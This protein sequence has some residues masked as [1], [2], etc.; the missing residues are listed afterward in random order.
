[1][2]QLSKPKPII[3]AASACVW[4]ERE[5][6]LIKRGND[7]GKGFWS[8][9]GGK[10][11]AGETLQACAHRELYEET[12]VT[13]ELALFVGEFPLETPQ[14]HFEIH[15]FTGHY[16]AGTACANTDALDVAWVNLE[17]LTH[18]TLTPHV[19]AAMALAFKLISV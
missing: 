2:H 4:R 10:L 17:D 16:V 18:F 1:M 11:E 6:L 13:A 8:L 14:A 5:V 19:L 3:K 12:G 7:L 9:P 15:N